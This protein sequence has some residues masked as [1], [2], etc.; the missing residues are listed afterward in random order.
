ME[1]PANDVINELTRVCGAKDLEL[2][3]AAV[4]I[5]TLQDQNAAQ[6]IVI[7]DYEERYE[8]E[9]PKAKEPKK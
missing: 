8:S 4:I 2:A 5:Q 1:L 9:D 7:A 3:K 6:A